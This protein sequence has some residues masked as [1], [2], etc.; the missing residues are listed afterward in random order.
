[1]SGHYEYYTTRGLGTVPK[2]AS[3][4]LQA[5]TAWVTQYVNHVNLHRSI[6]LLKIVEVHHEVEQGED[7]E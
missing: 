1:M 4:S 2:F 7:E 6:R 3:V 5:A